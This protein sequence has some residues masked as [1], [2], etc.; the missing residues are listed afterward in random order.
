[1]LLK[2]L[3][4]GCREVSKAS[5]T[6]RLLCCG[7]QEVRHAV[8]KRHL[9]PRLH[10]SFFH[11]STS[12]CNDEKDKDSKKKEGMEED[13][14]GNKEESGSF[15]DMLRKMQEGGEEGKNVNE[16]VVEEEEEGNTSRKQQQH[17]R[18][19]DT[20]FSETLGLIRYRLT[21]AYYNFKDQVIDA[22]KEMTGEERETMLSRKVEQAT[23]Y[24]KPKKKK[25]NEDGEE[26]DDD[27]EEEEVAYDGPSALVHVKEPQNAW[28]SMKQRLSESPLIQ[29]IL[30]NSKKIG[31]A[32]G[33]TPI[34]QQAHKINETVKGGIEDAKEFW[35]TSQN[36]IIYTL[37]GIV[38]NVT[39]ETEEG[40]ATAEIRRLDPKFNKEDWA[41]EVLKTL[42]PSVIGAHLEG[43]TKVLEP[44]CKE[45]VYKKLASEIRLRKGDG[46]VF[47]PNILDIDENQILVKYLDNEGAVIVGVYTVQQ[48]H[49]VKNRKG[50]IIDVSFCSF[51][52]VLLLLL[53]NV[54]CVVFPFDYKTQLCMYYMIY[55]DF[56]IDLRV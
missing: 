13:E 27:E 56:Y 10:V 7:R 15:K 33:E 25:L 12:R 42:V 55:D 44:F 51:Y 30:K 32:A 53:I 21:D 39:G 37:S 2:M 17:Q 22:W 16:K 48:I 45:A 34:G 26:I 38:E 24:R 50:E 28:E 1:M 18:E 36:P 46:I 43:K 5:A 52:L 47:D 3:T 6:T 41:E 9:Q 31:K 4:R 29:E 35:E 11:V 8:M 40:I 14:T 19:P 23:S 49:C 54:M 20:D